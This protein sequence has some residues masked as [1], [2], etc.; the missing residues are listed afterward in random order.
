MRLFLLFV[1][2]KINASMLAGAYPESQAK[3]EQT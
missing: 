3:A 2:S 1:L